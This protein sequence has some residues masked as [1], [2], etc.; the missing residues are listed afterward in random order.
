[1]PE[2]R[3]SSLSSV[4]PLRHSTIMSSHLVRRIASEFQLPFSSPHGP[5]HWMR[6]RLNGLLLAEETGVNPRVVELFALLHDSCRENDRYDPHHGPRAS[7]LA[8]ALYEHGLLACSEDE[9]ELLVAACYGH[10]HERSH[11]DETI[12]T[13]WDADRLDLPRVGIIPV[14]HRLCTQ[15]ARSATMIEGARERAETWRRKRRR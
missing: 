12:A 13:C 11:Y 14:P 1:M 7:M 5:A 15:A 9:L 10:T 4:Y 8:E 6:V 3:F 2:S